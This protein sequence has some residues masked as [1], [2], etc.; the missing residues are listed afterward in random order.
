MYLFKG[1]EVANFEVLLSKW[2]QQ[3]QVIWNTQGI[4]NAVDS[5]WRGI[6]KG[7]KGSKRIMGGGRIFWPDVEEKLVEEFKELHQKGLKVKHYWFRTQ[8]YQFM[9]KLYS[10]AEFQFSPG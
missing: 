8:S 1:E 3:V 10:G 2:M 9:H 4:P 7:K 5:K 6:Q